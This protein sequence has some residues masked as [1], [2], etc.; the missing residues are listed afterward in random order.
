MKIVVLIISAVVQVA[1]AIGFS[2]FI[3]NIK[4]RRK[5]LVAWNAKLRNSRSRI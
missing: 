2:W 5:G 1:L 4:K 3:P